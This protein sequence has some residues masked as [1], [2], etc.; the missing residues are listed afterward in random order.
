MP[1]LSTDIVIV[2]TCPYHLRELAEAMTADSKDVASR[3]GYTPLKALWHSYRNSLY[4]KTGLIDG[5][6]AAIWGLSGSM[7]A[8]VGKPWLI[9][10]P[11]VKQ[12]PLRI[13]FIYRKELNNMLKLFPVLE[14]WCPADN[15]PS[16]RML[17][18]MGFRVDKNITPIGG[19]EYRKAERRA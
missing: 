12:S 8:E 4:C 11:E 9:V 10:S 15:E 18:L 19:V 6:I 5:K 3:L 13:A 17:E 16:I 2:N 7:L 14:E 1:Q